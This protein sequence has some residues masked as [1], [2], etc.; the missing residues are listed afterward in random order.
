MKKINQR[1]RPITMIRTSIFFFLLPV[2][3]MNGCTKEEGI[4][5]GATIRGKVFVNEY[6]GGVLT[7]THD[8][9]EER[10]YLIFGNDEAYGDDTRTNYNGIYEFK[11]LYP[12]EYTVLVYTDC[13][14][15]SGGTE[16]VLTTMTVTKNKDV[17]E[18]EDIYVSR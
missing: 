11:Y 7:G 17:I 14:T 12:G 13:N 9:M 3:F 6:S 15:C 4:G 10:V 2:F 8:A 16:P 1:L 18:V 5:G